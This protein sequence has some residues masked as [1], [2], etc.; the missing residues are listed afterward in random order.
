MESPRRQWLLLSVVA[1][2]L[3]MD[4]LD[5][6]IVNVILPDMADHFGTDTGTISWVVTIYFLMMAALIL[7]FGKI[8]DSGAIKKL[9]II[10]L[11]TFAFSSL[12]VGLTNVF[13]VMLVFRAVQGV[14]AAMLAT[15]AFMLCVKYLPKKMAAFALSVGV[16][17]TSIG[18][19]VG[20]ALGGVLAEF[21][22]WHLVFFINLP[23]GII[24]A[25][26][27]HHAIPRDPGFSGRGFDIT[28]S[29]L[30]F[31][32]MIS[33]LYVMES[34][35]SNGFNATSVILLAVF[36]V[37]MALFVFVERRSGDPVLKLHLFGY[38]KLVATIVALILVNVVY[39]GC[40]YLLPFLLRIELGLDIIGS[41]MYLL[42]PAI[43]ILACCLWVG[44]I[45]DRIGNRPFVLAGCLTMLASAVLFALMT[46]GNLSALIPG[47][48]LM[49]ATWGLF[50]G[51]IGSRMLD[52]V[53]DED[54]PSS[55]ALMSFF[56]YFGCALGTAMFAALFGF[57][58][59]VP[60][61][62]I[63]SLSPEVFMDGFAFSM[64][65]GVVM[66]VAALILCL[67]VKEARRS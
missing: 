29:V 23:I 67:A 25:M 39:M 34:S 5:G 65:C 33:G 45:A 50:A 61:A 10:G 7:I 9:F 63:D 38:P 3:F 11:L 8:A 31:I 2:A 24:G 30:L 52:Q 46:D 27:A 36:A 60:D 58:S 48:I 66:S 42:I 6:T 26:V 59:G 32:A 4:G 51:P 28:G 40:L 17:G 37:S 1:L 35:P 57:G 12:F 62:E 56:T 44:K 19:A 21:Y 18:A 54:R 64:V 49:G 53:P 13:G 47:L 43:A 16:L 22:S 41:G 55:S 20:P 14:G 15:T